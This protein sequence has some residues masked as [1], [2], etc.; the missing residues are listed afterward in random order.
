MQSSADWTALDGAPFDREWQFWRYLDLELKSQDLKAATNSKCN[1]AS[2]LLESIQHAVFV[3]EY[4][5]DSILDM[6]A[7]GEALSGLLLMR[8]VLGC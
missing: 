2:G 4:D 6:E 3:V 8:H 7:V 5:L 1:A